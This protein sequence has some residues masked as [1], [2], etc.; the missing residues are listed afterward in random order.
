MSFAV[1]QSFSISMFSSVCICLSL[2]VS[3][4]LLFLSRMACVIQC[5]LFVLLLVGK[6][7]LRASD[8]VCLNSAQ[9]FSAASASTCSLLGSLPN[10]SYLLQTSILYLSLYLAVLLVPAPVALSL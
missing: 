7:S 10:T 9:L 3:F 4:L 6:F 8:I 5:F 1:L 2:L